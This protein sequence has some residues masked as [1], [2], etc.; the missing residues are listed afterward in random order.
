MLPA[1]KIAATGLLVLFVW[2]VSSI[3][4]QY[5]DIQFQKNNFDYFTCSYNLTLERTS[6]GQTSVHNKL[7]SKQCHNWKGV[8]SQSTVQDGGPEEIDSLYYVAVVIIGIMLY[9]TYKGFFVEEDVGI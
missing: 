3:I 5:E 1:I 6:D 9:F 2:L 8:R 4:L 7:Y